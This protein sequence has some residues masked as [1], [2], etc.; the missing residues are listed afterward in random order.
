MVLPT[1]CTAVQL[2]RLASSHSF[3]P[4][5]RCRSPSAGDGRAR[6]CA[7]GV[8]ISRWM[9]PREFYRGNPAAARYLFM[10]SIFSTK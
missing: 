1:R 8:H 3:R 5:W 2:R 4:V 10:A 9:T 7:C 6:R